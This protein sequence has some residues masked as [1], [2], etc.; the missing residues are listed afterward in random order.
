M[1][2]KT[3]TVRRIE[4]K[5]K[6]IAEDQLDVKILSAMLDADNKGMSKEPFIDKRFSRIYVVIGNQPI[7]D[8]N[9]S[10][11][12]EAAANDLLNKA[13]SVNQGVER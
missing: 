7:G 13:K 8:F 3:A 2:W 1:D 10:K 11:S 5:S 12:G 9:D 6:R 4:D